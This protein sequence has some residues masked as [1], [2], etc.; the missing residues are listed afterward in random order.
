[1]AVFEIDRNA[2]PLMQHRSKGA[3]WACRTRL[4]EKVKTDCLN[5]V[6]KIGQVFGRDKVILRTLAFGPPKEDFRLLGEMAEMLPRG[7]FQKLGL[8]ASNLR[9]AFSSLSSSMSE[10]RTEGGGSMLTPRADKVVN[11]EQK[12]DL[13]SQM[14]YGSDGWWIYSFG[15]VDRF[16]YD[17]TT[18][19]LKPRRMQQDTTGLAFFEEP[20]AEGAE[21]LVN[22]CALINIPEGKADSWYNICE[23]DTW[24][25]WDKRKA[26][27]HRCELRLVSKEA[28]AVENLHKG[29]RF[30]ETFA[31]VQY[32][33]G[34]LATAF[35]RRLPTQRAEWL[36][37]FLQTDVYRVRDENY[38]AGF[39]WVLVER[40][41]D[42]QFSKWN[43]NAGNVRGQTATQREAA[44]GSMALIEEDE[45][46][47]EDEAS[48]PI[49]VSEVPQAFSHFSYEHSRG[50]QLVCDLQ[51]VWNLDD[52]YVLT[53]PVVHYVS[54]SGRNKHKNGAT[55]K[56]IEGVKRF[57]SSHKCGPLC[58]KMGLP[59][60]SADNLID[61]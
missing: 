48:G 51:G 22:R 43:D 44:T 3:A 46:E 36:I 16:A 61:V 47:D 1:V 60:R 13:S 35:N 40:E 12:L 23:N 15:D 27:A 32:D 37:S 5:C 55:D 59:S 6:K 58:K 38:S 20:F 53:D 56:G 26:M 4:H 19:D 30:H 31:R 52:G 11:K 17:G 57:F 9:T 54:S 7:E 50:K 29:L 18:K 42:G 25:Y 39:A 45:D 24:P 10:L 28:R 49:E 41:L 2:D 21:R 33:A 34:V 14:L 8:D